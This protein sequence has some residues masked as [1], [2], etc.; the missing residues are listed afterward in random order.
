MT[1]VN[2]A[3]LYKSNQLCQCAMD[4]IVFAYLNVRFL[5][6]IEGNI[7]LSMPNYTGVGHFLK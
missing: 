7:S 1:N 3:N 2:N 4:M 5:V 6:G